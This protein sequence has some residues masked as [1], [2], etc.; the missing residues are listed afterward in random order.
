MHFFIN[1]AE[2]F[3]LKFLN[4]EYRRKF[5]YFI[6]HMIKLFPVLLA[7]LLV[8]SATQGCGSTTVPNI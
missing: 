5:I 7:C 6:L 2:N 3:M 8:F 4:S 1:P